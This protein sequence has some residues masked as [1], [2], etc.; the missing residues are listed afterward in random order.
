M[1]RWMCVFV[2]IGL[3]VVAGETR[4]ET[5]VD[6]TGKNKVKKADDPEIL[7]EEFEIDEKNVV[8]AATKTKKTLQETAQIVTVITAKD[9]A[10]RGF[11]TVNQALMTIPGFHGDRKELNGWQ[12]ESFSRGVPR[13]LLVLL[14]GINVTDPSR[15]NFILDYKIPIEI[16]K[17]IEVVSGPGGVLWGS[18]ALLGIVNII[19]KDAEDVKD[20]VELHFGYGDGPG[21]LRTFRAAALF[22]HSWFNKKLKLFTAVTFYSTK[23]P[24][25]WVDAQKLIGVTPPPSNEGLTLYLPLENRTLNHHRSWWLNWTGRLTYGPVS[26]EWMVPF[27]REYREISTGGGLLSADYRGFDPL[28]GRVPYVTSTGARDLTSKSDDRTMVFNVRYKDRFLHNKLGVNITAFYVNWRGAEDP[29]GS[30]VHT[31]ILTEGLFSIF[32]TNRIHRIGG[33]VDMDVWLPANNHLIFGGEV[34]YEEL[35]GVNTTSFEPQRVET[36]PASPT[37]S[38]CPAPYEYNPG[39]DAL[40]PCSITQP[41]VFDT[42]RIIGAL[43]VTNEWKPLPVLSLNLGGRIQL[44]N[45]YAPKF[46]WSG[47]AVWNIWQKIFLK[48]NYAQGFRPPSFQSTHVNSGVVNG[49]SLQGNPKL[50]VEESQAIE[51]ALSGV[52]LQ[53]VGPVRDL[54]IRVNYAYTLLTDLITRPR[55]AFVNAGDRRIHTAEVHFR[56]RFKGDHQFWIGYY[57]VDVHD[58]DTGPVRNIANHILNGGFSVHLYKRY[59]QLTATITVRGAMEDANKYPYTGV[60][61]ALIPGSL[62]AEVLAADVTVDKIPLLVLLNAGIRVK[63]I[64]KHHLEFN[65]FVY[66]ALDRRYT[67]PDFDFDQRSFSRPYPKATVGFMVNTVF[68]Y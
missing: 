38:S 17:R 43:F 10:E 32:S 65:A 29:F 8:I 12:Y 59:V 47:A 60:N 67:D 25:L 46:L 56:M 1:H 48:F 16:I 26:A 11:R 5:T 35:R 22:G 23:G 63:N 14:N 66:N 57:F 21:L 54:F 42:S 9:I 15:N 2:A 50:N 28:T 64:W 49:I 19:T 37:I 61:S 31:P 27:E 13:G 20:W 3:L 30:F 24:R 44:S 58:S 36:N 52:F 45:T 39:R 68:R 41:L 40:L 33:T 34:F 4:S 62:D 51:V 53:N 18:N 6:N 7:L 55:G